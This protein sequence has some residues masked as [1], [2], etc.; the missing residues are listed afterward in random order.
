MAKIS[1]DQLAG[2]VGPQYAEAFRQRQGELPPGVASAL[3]NLGLGSVAHAGLGST[4]EAR[5][6]S[7]PGGDR[8]LDMIANRNIRAIFLESIARTTELC[9]QVGLRVPTI[10]ELI[11]G[12]IDFVDLADEYG[13]MQGLK[14]EPELVV[15]PQYMIVDEAMGIF[16][17]GELDIQEDIVM[18]WEQFIGTSCFTGTLVEGSGTHDFW[19][20]RVIPATPSPTHLGYN[21]HGAGPTN[22]KIEQF[23]HPTIPEYLILQARCL[24]GDKLLDL[25]TFTW[26]AGEI[27]TGTSF[28]MS[29][30]GYSYH[31][32]K[33]SKVVR[34]NYEPQGDNRPDMG[35]RPVGVVGSY[36]A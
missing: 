7:L 5:E 8:G 4:S 22:E 23:S 6:S 36:N 17:P 9:S 25:T 24:R 19:S 15:A 12:G 33:S 20:V 27:L 34:I 28:S 32:S 14:Q 3:G 29:P 18:R 13:L 16:N 21:Y 35:I 1:P 10:D 11:G 26:L 2:L 31:E 30:I